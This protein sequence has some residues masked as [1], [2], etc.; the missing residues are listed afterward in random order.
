MTG[1][2]L[3]LEASFASSEEIYPAVPADG[4]KA[5]EQA[6][7]TA[8]KTY[9]AAGQ[10]ADLTVIGQ[11]FAY[12]EPGQQAGSRRPVPAPGR[13]ESSGRR[14]APLCELW[15]PLRAQPGHP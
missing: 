2:D 12:L 3:L 5:S 11:A 4:D 13:G 1:G 6:L 10:A 8:H 14:A 7:F 15:V 9:V